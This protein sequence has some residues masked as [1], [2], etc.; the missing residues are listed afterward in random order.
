V[1]TLGLLAG[2]ATALNL[3]EAPLP[4]LVPWAKPG[5]ANSAALLALMIYG[6]PQ[7][8]AV[9]LIRILLAGL[10]LGH[11]LSPGW[12]MG[13]AGA[14]GAPLAMAVCL[15]ASPPLGLLSVSAVGAVT[16]NALQLAV[17]SFVLVES[18]G[19]LVALPWMVVTALPA[20]AVVAWMTHAAASRLP[21]WLR[22]AAAPEGAGPRTAAPG[23]DS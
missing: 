23:G 20:G 22:D 13:A 21:P 1:A 18:R 4:R 2:Y 15:R 5:L 19:L 6:L 9:A 7:A 10:L 14:L 3:L 8:I 17:A 11:L 12:W 16:S